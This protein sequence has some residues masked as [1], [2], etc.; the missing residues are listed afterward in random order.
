[1]TDPEAI[2]AL[3]AVLPEE[4]LTEAG[5]RLHALYREQCDH[6]GP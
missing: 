2:A 3:V 4:R 1:V 6:E 5:K